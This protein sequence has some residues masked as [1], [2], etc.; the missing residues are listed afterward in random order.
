MTDQSMFDFV[1]EIDGEGTL[2]G[3]KGHE[4][5]DL[6]LS[7]SAVGKT[8]YEVFPSDIAQPIMHFVEKTLHD[9]DPQ[10]F[11]Y[12]HS[13][14][15]KKYYVEAR[16]LSVG[17]DRVLV[18]VR[19]I[20]GHKHNA[21]HA[22]HLSNHD[23]LTNLPNRYLFIDRLK[24]AILYAERKKMLM[25]ILFI[26]LDNFKRINDTLG[27]NIGDQLLQHAA[28]RLMKCL[29]KTDSI[30]RLPKD[31]SDSVVARMGGDEF[32]L[33][34][35][36]IRDTKE[37]SQ[38]SKRILNIL[39]EPFTID[40]QEI[41]ITASV[42]IAVYPFDGDDIDIMMKNADVAMYQAKRQGRNNY[43]FYSESMNSFT[44][45]RFT[46]ENKLWKALEKNEFQLFYQPQID[47][48]T[49][50]VI[51]VEAL[52]RWLQ[53]DLILVKPKDF[54]PFAEGSGLIIK[55]GEWVMRTACEQNMV[56]QKAGLNPIPVTVNIS[57]TQ[58]RQDDFVEI[59]ERILQDTG[60]DSKYLHLE[61][62]ETIIMQSDEG[63]ITKLKAL[64]A[65]GI[66]IALDDF[67]TGYSS[68]GYL[69]NF[70]ISTLKIDQSFIHNLYT[71][72]NDQTISKAIIDLG[73]N[74][75]LKVIAEGVE[76]LKQL[77]L[78]REYGCDAVQGYLVCPPLN[79]EALKQFIDNQL[80]SHR[81]RKVNNNTQQG[82]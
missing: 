64:D 7:N 68:M 23:I 25:A 44:I 50:E 2:L 40:T 42:G 53:P 54:I 32:T 58:F 6:I 11:E 10:T 9:R 75:N 8:I 67:G 69:K 29:R 82:L 63:T 71:N 80:Y 1:F 13:I 39:A 5:N 31:E 4:N 38:V 18:I 62:T 76:N 78:L 56:W 46:M 27:H 3:Y 15:G 20:T 12:Q 24:H 47:I 49:K 61:L 37:I 60:L 22:M 30:A 66:K 19:D 26:D 45:E 57:S 28:N 43:Q 41:F 34:L 33:I 35:E 16:F 79:H 14:Q 70:P 51:G 52:I 36:D 55:I 17:T 21:D 65:L 81:L 74:F 72:K 48:S 77:T 73:H 59:V